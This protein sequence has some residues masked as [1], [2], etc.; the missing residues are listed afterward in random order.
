LPEGSN[1][2]IINI[3]NI[4]LI[5]AIIAVG[6]KYYKAKTNSQKVVALPTVNGNEAQPLT[7][8]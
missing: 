4:V 1:G 5:I 6:F 2:M 8:I 3:I 7:E